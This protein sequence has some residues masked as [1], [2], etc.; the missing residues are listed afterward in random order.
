MSDWIRLRRFRRMYP[1]SIVTVGSQVQDG[2]DIGRGVV[3][4]NSIV[5]RSSSIGRFTTLGENCRLAGLGRIS[6]G[7]FCS[8]G[9]DCSIR[10]DNHRLD[11]ISTYPFNQIE[12]GG[13]GTEKDYVAEPVS[14]GND[15]WLGEGVTVLPGANIGDGCVIA[16]RSVVARGEYPPYSIIAGIPGKVIRAR[17]PAESIAAIQAA[18]WWNEAEDRIFG[19]L[20]SKL[21]RTVGEGDS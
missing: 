12:D 1:E 4:R 17:I 13:A 5:S 2:A 15:V 10:S 16:A 3:I 20:R 21:T 19:E 6:I 8:I 7:Q 14:I 9:P 11:R 18:P